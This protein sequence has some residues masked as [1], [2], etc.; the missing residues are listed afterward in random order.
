[1]CFYYI[2]TVLAV[3]L[4]MWLDAT[5]SPWSPRFMPRSAHV[6]FVVDRVASGQVLPKFFGFPLSESF[7]CMLHIHI[8]SRG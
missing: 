3:L 4:L 6:G 1:M 5:I 2:F 8:L 7:Y